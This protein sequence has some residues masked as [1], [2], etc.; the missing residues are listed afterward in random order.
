VIAPYLHGKVGCENDH[1]NIVLVQIVFL[2]YRV[3]RVRNYFQW[4]SDRW[5]PPHQLAY[6]ISTTAIKVHKI[7]DVH[8]P[9]FWTLDL[10]YLRLLDGGQPV[11]AS[12]TQVL[13]VGSLCRTHAT[14]R[15]RL[16]SAST[17]TTQQLTS[18][19]QGPSTK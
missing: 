10:R 2:H 15:E 12:R 18:A 14:L 4:S 9:K 3:S 5:H 6:L 16:I 11:P 8:C 19:H 13:A 17:R 7:D 1:I